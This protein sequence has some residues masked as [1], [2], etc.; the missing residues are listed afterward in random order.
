MIKKERVEENCILDSARKILQEI[1]KF[2]DFKSNQGEVIAHL[3]A[4]EN[5]VVIF[6]TGGGKSLVYQIPAL[7]FDG[8]DERCGRPKGQGLTLVICPLIALM[9]VTT[10]E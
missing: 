9:K 6:P 10:G 7:A 5:A 2:Q 8:N 3:I 4:G 1:W